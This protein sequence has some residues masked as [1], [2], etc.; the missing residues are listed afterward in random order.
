MGVS[1]IRMNI[2]RLVLNGFEQHEARALSEDLQSQ[3][4]H[5]LADKIGRNDWMRSH[6]T[7]VVKLGA[8]PLEHGTSGTRKLGRRIGRAVGKG[9]KP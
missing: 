5:V 2:D 7:P 9:L 8:V 4:L 3:L 1:R 6:R